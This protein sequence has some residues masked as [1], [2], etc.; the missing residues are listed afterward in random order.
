VSNAH[1]PTKLLRRSC[2]GALANLGVLTSW[3]AGHNNA[4]LTLNVSARRFSNE[5]AAA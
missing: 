4:I 3:A 2:R 1:R 5:G